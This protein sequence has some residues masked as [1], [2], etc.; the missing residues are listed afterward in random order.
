M[1]QYSET[2][3][4]PGPARGGKTTYLVPPWL[5]VKRI[6]FVGRCSMYENSNT[7]PV[8]TRPVYH[9]AR[10][11]NITASEWDS[12]KANDYPVCY[13]A[14]D[15]PELE[16]V[17]EWE[18]TGTVQGTLLVYP[19]LIPGY[20]PLSPSRPFS[21]SPGEFAVTM[22]LLD[23]APNAVG[24]F[25]LQLRWEAVP[26]NAQ[27]NFRFKLGKGV[28]L[29]TRHPLYIA[30]QSPLLPDQD[31]PVLTLD[32]TVTGTPK[33]LSR[34]AAC[35]PG[36]N[37]PATSAQEVHQVAWAVNAAVN[38][39]TPPYFNNIHELRITHDG[40]PERHMV[41]G[42]GWKGT[43]KPI[44]V[45]DQWL[46]WAPSTAPHWNAGSCL[47][48]VQLLKT[49]LA[50]AGINIERRLIYPTTRQLPPP[51]TGGPAPPPLPMAAVLSHLEGTLDPT[52]QRVIRANAQRTLLKTPSGTV[53]EAEV[54]LMNDG[55]QGEFYE[56]CSRTPA[57][58]ARYFPGGFSSARI[59]SGAPGFVTNLG[60]G[61]ALETHRW[62]VRTTNSAGTFQRFLAWVYVDR[63]SDTL[64][65]CWDRDGT[66]YPPSAY[67]SIRTNGKDLLQP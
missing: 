39:S 34:L 25:E 15:V 22:S 28:G 63:A 41:P 11:P 52:T 2:G 30:C 18:G 47:C 26:A 21:G 12:S 10:G 48:H 58:I 36:G 14:G 65:H 35:F 37:L 64:L 24:R 55:A 59:A 56:G 62:W 31:S 8:A 67:V 32:D 13:I 33:R 51:V 60:F 54:A 3:A 49:M 61:S 20:A 45:E 6:R 29:T 1:G 4:L 66:H 44:P 40:T 50:T 5:V 38:D 19:R 46:M 53:L 57:P 9:W 23:P 27:C 16:I 43:G 42:T 17:L 7:H